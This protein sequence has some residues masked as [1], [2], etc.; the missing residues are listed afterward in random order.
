MIASLKRY[1]VILCIFCLICLAN[2]GLAKNSN[3][4]DVGLNS[5]QEKLNSIKGK[6]NGIQKRVALAKQ[7]EMMALAK[8]QKTQQGLDKARNS[9]D[10]KQK[11]LKNIEDN[12]VSSEQEIKDTEEK[13]QDRAYLLKD[14]LRQ[15]HTRKLNVLSGLLQSIFESKTIVDL[16]NTLY[17]QKKLIKKE[18][19][20]IS[21]VREQQIQLQE[22]QRIWQEQKEELIIAAKEAKE[23][24]DIISQKRQKQ[25]ELVNRFRR[26]RLAY[27][28]S[29]RKLERE[30][31]QLTSR[32]LKLSNSSINIRDLVQ[33]HYNYPVRASI[34]SRFGYRRHPIFRTRS[35][36]SGLDFGAR[37]G[38]PIR[39]AN[40]GTVIY[41]KWYGGYG[42][43]V[44]VSHGNDKST[45]YA[46]LQ[47]ISSRVGQKVAQGDV[48]GY[49][50]TTGISTGPHLHFEYRESGRAKNPLLVLKR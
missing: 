8:L 5:Y 22:S 26:E 31:N 16:V 13:L 3:S 4:D 39:S 46:H 34:T 38:T 29:E 33:P 12:L 19:S 1:R 35:F 20:L 40:G 21:D 28:I 47:R 48:I 41:A 32:I 44:I 43:T 18:L 11:Q 24:R 9:Y 25:S 10:A 37:Y 15:M 14:H 6:K 7:K 50:G 2:F 49:T 42:K 30:A 45:L 27:E 23:L 36:H 17:Y